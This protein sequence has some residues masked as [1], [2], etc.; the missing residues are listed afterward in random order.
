M[1]CENVVKDAGIWIRIIGPRDN[2]I[3]GEVAPGR[4]PLKSTIDWQQY[5]VTTFVPTD[6]MVVD[7]GFVMDATGKVW[8]DMQSVKCEVVDEPGKEGL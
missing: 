6:A 1:K 3:A 2:Y 5:T 7:W 4:R 8:I